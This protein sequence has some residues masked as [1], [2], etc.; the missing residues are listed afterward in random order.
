MSEKVYASIEEVKQKR[1]EWLNDEITWD[2]YTL[3]II[4]NLKDYIKGVI[5]KPFRPFA[6]YEDLYQQAITAVVANLR[7]YDP[8]KAA[9]TT[10]F[11]YVIY[12]D[13]KK[14]TTKKMP[15][16][17][18]DAERIINKKLEEWGYSFKIGDDQV[19]MQLMVDLAKVLPNTPLVT[20]KEVHARAK[21]TIGSLEDIEGSAAQDIFDNPEKALLNKEMSDQLTKVMDNC[22]NELEQFVVW[23]LVVYEKPKEQDKPAELSKQD[24]DTEAKKK[25]NKESISYKELSDILSAPDMIERYNLKA[26]GLNPTEVQGIYNRAMAKLRNSRNLKRYYNNTNRY[27]DYEDVEIVSQEDIDSM[28]LGEL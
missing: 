13:L 5:I 10:Y 17:Y 19:T 21:V 23:A 2:A 25:R 18:L 24:N 12:E 16:H 15:Q 4:E 1:Q 7:E 20:I 26:S 11:K 6:E 9:P 28:M 3:F 27:I 8:D 22:L 14:I